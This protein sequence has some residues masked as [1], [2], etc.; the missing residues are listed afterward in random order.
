MIYDS[1]KSCVIGNRIS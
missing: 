1:S